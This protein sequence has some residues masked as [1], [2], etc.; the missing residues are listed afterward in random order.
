[1]QFDERRVKG[2]ETAMLGKRGEADER[3]FVSE[4]R[5]VIVE[6]FCCLSRRGCTDCRPNLLQSAARGLRHGEKIF[7][8]RSRSALLRTGF[9]HL[10]STHSFVAFDFAI[11]I[12]RLLRFP[13]SRMPV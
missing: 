3:S 13:Q 4:S 7:V 12:V 2:V 10:D 8:N 11:T 9:F 5:H 1:M 6:P